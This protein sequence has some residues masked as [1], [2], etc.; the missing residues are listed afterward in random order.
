MLVLAGVLV[1]AGLTASHYVEQSEREALDDRLKRTAELSSATARA[2]IEQELPENDR[3]LD[4]VLEAS[5]TSLRLLLGRTVLLETGSPPPSRPAPREGLRT[6]T[7]DGENYRS[8][9]TTIEDPDL[10]GL[11]LLQVTTPLAALEERQADLDRRLLLLGA[12]A[13][14]L[15]AAGALLAAGL[16]L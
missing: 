14:L 3:R 2:A 10:G 12:L 8:Y 15:G 7:A 16:V 4:A 5:G 1:V 13:L 9:T 11:A 6:F